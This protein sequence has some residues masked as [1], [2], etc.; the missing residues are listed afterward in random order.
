MRW[1]TKLRVKTKLIIIISMVAVFA[2]IGGS[3]GTGASATEVVCIIAINVLCAILLALFL[4]NV[5]NKP[6]KEINFL[7]KEY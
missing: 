2:G 7:V 1:F 3:I 4:S 6:L 5:V